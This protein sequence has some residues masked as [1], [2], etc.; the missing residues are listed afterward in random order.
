MTIKNCLQQA[1]DSYDLVICK[2]GFS[3]K[4]GGLNWLVL[5]KGLQCKLYTELFY[6]DA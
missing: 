1:Y 5:K 2:N 6:T 3:E 4:I